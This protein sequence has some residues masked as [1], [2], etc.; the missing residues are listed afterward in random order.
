MPETPR[1]QV[2]AAIEGP[3]TAQARIRA[4]EINVERLLDQV[5][6]FVR[7]CQRCGQ[8]LWFVRLKSGK[9]GPYNIDGV[10][11]FATCRFAGEFRKPEAGK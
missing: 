4:L 5:A 9:I 3:E 1:A 11:H 6:D 7:P 2:A 10:S 8:K